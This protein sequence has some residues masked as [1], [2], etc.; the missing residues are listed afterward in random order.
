M[1]A[2]VHDARFPVDPGYTLYTY[3]D[4]TGILLRTITIHQ[5]EWIQDYDSGYAAAV[6]DHIEW[7]A[8]VPV[9]TTVTIQVRAADSEAAFGAGLATAWC[10]P[11]NTP[12]PSSGPNTQSLAGCPF[13][14][15]HRWLQFDVKLGT[16]IDGMRPSAS[17]FKAY[18]SY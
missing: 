4:M 8:N 15:G 16:T 14:N 6:W 7:T 11:F 2:G 9:G 12:V 10:G 18:W 1:R 17:D 5:G 13:L 3:S